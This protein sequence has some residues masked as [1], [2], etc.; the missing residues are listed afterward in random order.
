MLGVLGQLLLVGQ[1]VA[2]AARGAQVGH[3]VHHVGGVGVLAQVAGRDALVEVAIQG[4]VVG[5]VGDV[6]LVSAPTAPKGRIC[7]PTVPK[8]PT[9]ID[10]MSLSLEPLGAGL[11]R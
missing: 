7:S 5:D 3:G 9:S 1:R 8:G 10:S 11:G 4:H 2:V 6:A